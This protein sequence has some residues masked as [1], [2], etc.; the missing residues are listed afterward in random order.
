MRALR[1]PGAHQHFSCYTWHHPHN[2]HCHVAALQALLRGLARLRDTLASSPG[3]PLLTAAGRAQPLVVVDLAAACAPLLLPTLNGLLLAYPVVYCVHDREGASAAARCLSGQHLDLHR[4]VAAPPPALAAAV[5][6]LRQGDGG[7]N[8]NSGGGSAADAVCA[9]TVPAC[10]CAAS[11]TQGGG[12]S[13][14]S[15]V[16]EWGRRMQQALEAAGWSGVACVAAAV[17][18]GC[19][20]S[21]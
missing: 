12:C 5:A 19:A 17:G 2:C 15:R 20:V 8:S 16:E 18:S 6:A 4:A 13:V 1:A 11:E 10:L 7:N 14:A 9:F 21:L 3:V